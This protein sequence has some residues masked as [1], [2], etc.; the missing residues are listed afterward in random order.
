MIEELLDYFAT[1]LDNKDVVA[2]TTT[3]AQLLNEIDDMNEGQV[4]YFRELQGRAVDILND[5]MDVNF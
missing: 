2:I 4:S 3:E 5:E 1:A